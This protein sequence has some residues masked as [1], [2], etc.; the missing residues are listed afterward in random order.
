VAISPMKLIRMPVSMAGGTQFAQ[1]E[2]IP[3]SKNTYKNKKFTNFGEKNDN[4][5]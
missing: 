5:N 4:K 3:I 1:V 2:K